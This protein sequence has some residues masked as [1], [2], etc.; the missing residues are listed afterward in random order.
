MPNLYIYDCQ[1]QE[2]GYKWTSTPMQNPPSG[3]PECES[4]D[5]NVL[6]KTQMSSI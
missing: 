6:S 2:C 3:C 4:N 1:C 5:I